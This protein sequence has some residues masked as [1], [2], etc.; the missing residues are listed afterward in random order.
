[1]YGLEVGINPTWRG[2]WAG[3]TAPGAWV[4]DPRPYLKAL[5]QQT[6]P[7]AQPPGTK[8]GPGTPAAPVQPTSTPGSTIQETPGCTKP[9]NPL[10]VGGGISYAFCQAR[11]TLASFGEH[12]AVFIIALLLIIAGIYLIGHKQINQ[13][14][15][16]TAKGAGKTAGKAGEVAGEAAV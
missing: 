15:V 8:T 13:F 9:T 2:V 1:M 11:N 7:T 16:G 12:I 4:T 6:T 5:A 10:D 3:N 14:V